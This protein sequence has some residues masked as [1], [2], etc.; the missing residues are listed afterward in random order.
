M[1]V[2]ESPEEIAR[3]LDE[4]R[5]RLKEFEDRVDS[6][7]L[8]DRLRANHPYH[9]ALIARRLFGGLAMLSLLAGIGTLAASMLFAAPP[10]WLVQLDKISA[11]SGMPL[12]LVF[13]TLALCMGIARVMASQAAYSFARDCPMNPTEMREHDRLVN[14][15]KRLQSQKAILDRSRGTPMG[16]RPR[17]STPAPTLARY[18]PVPLT[19]RT[20]GSTGGGMPSRSG[21]PQPKPAERSYTPPVVSLSPDDATPRPVQR[22]ATPLGT[23]PRAGSAVGRLG[24][25][26]DD[27]R[28]R[29]GM[30]F[31]PPQRAEQ[32]ITESDEA[33]PTGGRPSPVIAKP[34]IARPAVSAPAAGGFEQRHATDFPKWGA[35]DEPWLEDAIQKSELLAS[36]FPVQARLL[37]SAEPAL[38]FSLVLERAT[39]AMAVRAM[40]SYIE[41]LASISTPPRAR[42]QLRSVPHLDRS[43]HRN[44]EAA[45]EPY[46]ADRVKVIRQAEHIDIEFSDSD[47]AW[48]EY[49]LLPME[50]VSTG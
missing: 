35:V 43:F 32:A 17:T 23:A 37:F 3:Q 48:R 6:W 15:L 33:T 10:D 14:E 36:G 46:F 29:S 41:F 45:L 34:S 18:S 31:T 40:V 12:P 8:L 1:D 50:G 26:G 24:R 4:A 16:A 19:S 28:S 39:P 27:D 44:V 38:P 42:I 20:G 13:G 5:K 25:D 11:A 7:S 47:P 22:T 30:T 21:A 9:P 2:F 49:P